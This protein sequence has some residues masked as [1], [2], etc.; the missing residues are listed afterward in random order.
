MMLRLCRLR[1]MPR[2]G[3][4]SGGGACIRSTRSTARVNVGLV[5]FSGSAAVDA[6][7][8]VAHNGFDSCLDTVGLGGETV[9]SGPQTTLSDADLLAS[10]ESRMREC[11][12]PSGATAPGARRSLA[13]LCLEV[14]MHR[15]HLLG[16]LAVDKV[17]PLILGLR[18]ALATDCATRLL[19]DTLSL[20]NEYR[21]SHVLALLAIHARLGHVAEC[22]SLAVEFGEDPGPVIGP[23]TP[24][25]LTPG[26]VITPV[27]WRYVIESLCV[28]D[29]PLSALAAVRSKT[30]P[31]S[32][33]GESPDPEESLNSEETVQTPQE[34]LPETSPKAETP[35]WT[36]AV[37]HTIAAAFIAKGEHQQALNTLDEAAKQGAAPSVATRHQAIRAL[38]GLHRLAPAL[39]ELDAM[40][41]N[42]QVP[43][44]RSFVAI[45]RAALFSDTQRPLAA[46]VYDRM[47]AAGY[48]PNVYTYV[49]FMLAY[50]RRNLHEQVVDLFAEMSSEGIV[51]EL[52]SCNQLIRALCD[53]GRMREAMD[54][55]YDMEDCGIAPDVYIYSTLM[56]GFGKIGDVSKM[57][58]LYAEMRSVKLIEPTVNTFHI[59]MDG[60]ARNKRMDDVATTMK[61]MIQDGFP[62]SALAYNIWIHGYVRL[63]QLKQ[64]ES[65]VKEMEEK[66]DLP[67]PTAYTYNTLI[68]GYLE[69]DEESKAA[70]LFKRMDELALSAPER[71]VPASD[72]VTF[73]LFIRYYAALGDSAAFMDYY[74]TLLARNIQPNIMTYMPIINHYCTTFNLNKA[75]EMHTEA[76]TRGVTDYFGPYTL[77]MNAYAKSGDLDSAI[78]EFE[79]GVTL[80]IRPDIRT[81]DILV[82]ANLRKADYEKAQHWMNMMERTYH[83][84]KDARSF[85]NQLRGFM[86]QNKLQSAISVLDEML[87]KK[88]P[89]D[90]F[91]YTLMIELNGKI[92]AC[93]DESLKYVMR[94]LARRFENAKSEPDKSVE[95][96]LKTLRNEQRRRKPYR[97][98][99]IAASVEAETG[100]EDSSFSSSTVPLMDSSSKPSISQ[101]S[102]AAVPEDDA[103]LLAD[104]RY[105]KEHQF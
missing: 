70:E 86:T 50:S 19:E 32:V 52:E 74:R 42:G 47:L 48:S 87:T 60:Y 89:Q 44:Q 49:A 4:V 7:V 85:N 16:K 71:A 21:E 43:A 100:A 31:L 25:V 9:G 51:P 59:L 36:Q 88:I 46:T 10:I 79:K 8:D 34:T 82:T 67:N 27:A 38:I 14:S 22:V 61:V 103:L 65:V 15:R 94:L 35:G 12:S 54:V 63:K 20:G 30:L 26:P 105:A 66:E 11:G 6:R 96:V 40:T 2:L 64:A 72:I 93:D 33:S 75:Y 58:A 17:L 45:L 53:L 76:Q 18:T 99:W 3:A 41:Q 81:F 78:K 91:T 23:P 39:D 92:E 101:P 57:E 80:K 5:R 97:W 90:M 24:G 1:M 68:M 83:L 29:G 62:V 95:R 73:N 13:A 55:F 98:R 84:E 104:L 77:I 28:A 56:D 37:A 69:S 102:P